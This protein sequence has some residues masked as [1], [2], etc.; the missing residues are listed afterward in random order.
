MGRTLPTR[1]QLL[2]FV[3]GAD[4]KAGSREIAHAFDVRGAERDRLEDMLRE[5]RGDG[6]LGP[7]QRADLPPV[8]VIEITGIDHDGEP[9]ARIAGKEGATSIIRFAADDRGPAPGIGDRLLVRRTPNGAARTIKRLERAPRD[10]L[11]VLEIVDGRKR[12]I[13]TNRRIKT[14]RP[15]V[16]DS[17][18]S[19]GSLVVARTGRDGRT[20]IV[21]TVSEQA[22]PS[23]IAL[24]ARGIPTEFSGEALADA[25]KAEPVPPEDRTDLRTVPLVTI[26]GEDARD[27]DDA[28]W[29]EPSSEGGWHLVVA[30]ADVAWYVRPDS[31]LDQCAR[32]RGNSVYFP[33]RVVPMLPKELSDGLCSLV[34]GEN[35]GCLAVHLWIDADGN[36]LRHEFVRGIMRSAGRLT[37]E[38]VEAA[39]R[40]AGPLADIVAP[41]YGAFEALFAARKRR[42]AIDLD[43]PERRVLL[44]AGGEIATIAPTARLGSHRLVE[45]FMIAANVAAAETLERA[46]CMYRVHDRPPAGKIEE[47]R[48]TLRQ[49][50]IRLGRSPRAGNLQRVIER[51]AAMPEAHMINLSVLR[52]QAQAEYAPGNI[53]HFGLALGRY[54][55]FTSP[56]RRY[57]D[58]LV[59][60]S[61]IAAEGLGEGG[62]RSGDSAAFAGLGRHLS[63]T[64][65]RA[66][67]AE[68]EVLDRYA[69]IYLADRVGAEFAAHIAGVH[70]AGL[71][72][73]LDE[74]GANGFVPMSALGDERFDFGRLRLTGRVS[75]AVYAIGD[76]VTARLDEANVHTG[77]LIFSIDG[78]S[79]GLRTDV[80]EA[81]RDRRRP[82]RAAARKNGGRR[83]NGGKRIP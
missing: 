81:L 42:G 8:A 14:G 57:A 72:V 28:V 73:T 62:L 5:L 10:I 4:G 58:L 43:L 45:E 7:E 15:I 1:E 19:P 68:R 69:T 50:G 83:R 63:M 56:I 74:T 53:G 80:D 9:I 36:P 20:R 61:L 3:R 11:G 35:R 21:E 17:D 27:F 41:L 46:P 78:C 47:L 76:P 31:P 24:H 6:E 33:D 26:D 64:E 2:E 13:P 55:H 79:F 59:H 67:E 49:I 32:E 18:V 54:A 82:Q 75:G 52:A 30:I 34:P 23:A 44:D 71:F 22:Q 37:Y 40:G 65:R 48:E 70:R 66:A 77:S 60:R 39:R 29:A 51:A 16:P 12:I 38:G 25:S